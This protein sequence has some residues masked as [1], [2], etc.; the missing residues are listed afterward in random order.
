MKR[1]SVLFIF[2]TLFI[3]RFGFGSDLTPTPA[4]QV[5][6]QILKPSP[7]IQKKVSEIYI[8]Y[9]HLQADIRDKKLK[10]K[11]R[12]R[13]HEN[14][15]ADKTMYEDEK[16]I[17]RDYSTSWGSDDSAVDFEYIYDATG[18][19]RMVITHAGYVD[20]DLSD[21]QKIFLDEKSNVLEV[22]HEWDEVR[23]LD[24]NTGDTSKT[25]KKEILSEPV[26]CHDLKVDLKLDPLKDYSAAFDL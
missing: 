12:E 3:C 15:G 7:A 2:L 5:T 9:A 16:S 20:G 13:Y 19:L 26:E 25:R 22:I 1:I 21:D 11:H 6:P 4:F 10:K 18:L 23:L 24:D 8:L 17:V 14:F